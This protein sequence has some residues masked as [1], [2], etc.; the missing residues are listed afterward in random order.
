MLQVLLDK[1]LKGYEVEENHIAYTEKE[2]NF[3]EFLEKLKVKRP[4]TNSSV[5]NAVKIE[6]INNSE[7]PL[8]NPTTSPMLPTD[9]PKDKLYKKL[10]GT[11]FPPTYLYRL[12]LLG[13]VVFD[14]KGQNKTYQIQY[15]RLVLPAQYSQKGL[16]EVITTF[17]ATEIQKYFEQTRKAKF[18]YK[19]LKKKITY[20][21]GFENQ[22]FD[23]TIWESSYVYE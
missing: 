3:E 5:V 9:L 17:K 12:Q 8:N 6:D 2:Q 7:T 14:E 4:N 11:Y 15:V 1:D 20:L 18:K 16:D 10:A 22:A 13:K 23:Y 19:P 21:Q